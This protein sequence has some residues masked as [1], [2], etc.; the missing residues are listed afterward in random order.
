MEL[1]ETVVRGFAPSIRKQKGSPTQAGME[2]RLKGVADKV[3]AES[4]QHDTKTDYK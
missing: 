3:S 2:E 1:M 4:K